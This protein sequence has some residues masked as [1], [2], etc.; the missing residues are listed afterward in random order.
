MIDQIGSGIRRMFET[1]RE[2]FFPLP[3]YLIE[4]DSQARPRIEVSISGKIMDAKYTRILMKRPDLGLHEVLLLDRVQKNQ[5]ITRIEV[6]QLKVQKLIEGRSPNYYISAKVA[7]WAGQ[8]ADYIRNRALDD[9]YYKRLVVE[10]LQ[11]FKHASRQEL[12]DLLLPKLSDALTPDQKTHKVRNLIQFL[13][14]DGIILNT[15]TNKTPAW[16]LSD[17]K[18]IAKRTKEN[19]D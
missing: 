3:D 6:K 4:P 18:V 5:R 1:Q 7:D 9:D 15:G 11:K 17:K 10:Y 2:R 19:P 8:K 12:N 13:R 16:V 14:R